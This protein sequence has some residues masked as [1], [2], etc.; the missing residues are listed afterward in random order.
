M[1]YLLPCSFFISFALLAPRILHMLQLASYQTAGFWRWL[2]EN[3]PGLARSLWPAL[4]VLL[5]GLWPFAAMPALA[6]ALLLGAAVQFSLN[7]PKA[8]KPLKYTARLVRVLATGLLLAGGVAAG[9]YFLFPWPPED[10]ARF[11]YVWYGAF[12]LAAPLVFLLANWVTL[13]VQAL[14]NNGYIRDAKRR[15]AAHPG[16]LVIGVT[17]SYGKTSVKYFLQKLLS[18]KYNVLM[19]P[20]SYNTPM[21]VVRTIRENLNAT[22]EVFVCEMGARHAGDIREICDIVHPVHGILTAVG[23][24][25]LE[26]F[27]SLET[28]VQTKYELVNALLEGGTAFLGASVPENPGVSAAKCVRYAAEPLANSRTAARAY[29]IEA[30]RGGT[31]FTVAIEGEAPQDFY[32]RLLG[33]HNVENLLGA[34]TCAHSLGIPLAAMTGAARA[35]EPVPHRLQLLAGDPLIIDDAF[36][37]NPVGAA[38]ALETL[39]LFSGTKI[40]VTP[41]MV[42]LGARQD[43]LNEAFGAQAA[44]VCDFICLVG[45][46]Q[47]APVANGVQ[48]AGFPPERLHVFATVLEAIAFAKALNA[49][50]K[51]VLLENDLPDNY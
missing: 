14:I 3:L 47:T 45:A 51:V 15:L 40:L 36:N 33:V 43:E 34:I 48:K 30:G 10:A 17:G 22:H 37:A 11:Y 21:G 7:R 12:F 41:G 25:H 23:E 50:D 2:R 29:G 24:Q 5:L 28:I 20:E 35:L 38:A 4:P 32:T 49:P 27:G 46:K 6:A 16:L 1:S 8:K 13:P 18:A 42:E 44:G 9:G 26:T 39:A 31:R 19:T